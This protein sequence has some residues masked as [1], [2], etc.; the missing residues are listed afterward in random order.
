MSEAPTGAAPGLGWPIAPPRTSPSGLGW[1]PDPSPHQ[2]AAR[3]TDHDTAAGA[4]T[5]ADTDTTTEGPA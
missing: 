2:T 3:A 1:P 5:D 4:D